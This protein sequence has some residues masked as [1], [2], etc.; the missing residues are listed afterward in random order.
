MLGAVNTGPTTANGVV[1]R[2]KIMVTPEGE[3]RLL[4]I[5]GVLQHVDVINRDVRV[6]ATGG[7]TTFDVPPGCT[8]LLNGENVKLRLLQA[9][10]HV[11]VIYTHENAAQIAVHIEAGTPCEHYEKVRIPQERSNDGDE[12]NLERPRAEAPG[13]L[14]KDSGGHHGAKSGVDRPYR[15]SPEGGRRSDRQRGQRRCCHQ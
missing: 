13:S 5:E 8:I 4:E 3:A 14:R 12:Q 11:R 10:D 9:H 2:V 15:K 1:T 7:V 6:F